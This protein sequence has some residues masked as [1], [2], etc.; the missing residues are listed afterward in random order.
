MSSDDLDGEVIRE[1]QPEI[2]RLDPVTQQWTAITLP[3][4]DTP[5]PAERARLSACSASALSRGKK[6]PGL[7]YQ[8]RCGWLGGGR[9][10][11]ARRVLRHHL[12]VRTLAATRGGEADDL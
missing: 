9:V 8:R 2:S 3:A 1:G 4:A 10:R 5:E 6:R 7:S 11:P 12:R